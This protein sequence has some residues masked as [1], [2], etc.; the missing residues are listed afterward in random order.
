MMIRQ[1]PFPHLRKRM[2]GMPLFPFLG[3]LKIRRGIHHKDTKDT[4]VGRQRFILRLVSLH[5]TDL[6]NKSF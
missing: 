4:E 1:G 6:K 5:M 2:P 3:V